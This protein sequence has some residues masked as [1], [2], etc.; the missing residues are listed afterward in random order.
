MLQVARLGPS[1]LG[2]EASQLIESFILSQQD[3][4]GGFLDR[5]GSPDLYYTSF[6]IDALTALQADLPEKS[7]SSYLDQ[8]LGGIEDLD[9]VH[10]CCLARATSALGKYRD[11]KLILP[12][13]D[14]IENYRTGDGGYNQ[15]EDHP[16]GST[17]ACFLAWGAYSDHVGK[18]K[19]K[20][21]L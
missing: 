10:L 15:S 6:A 8:K 5:D 21:Q 18:E 1:V 7:L 20:I 4:S 17:Y 3:V 9:F 13:L 19:S 14:Q 2:A 12:L 16:T 11:S